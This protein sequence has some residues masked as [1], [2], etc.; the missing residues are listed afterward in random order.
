M[1]FQLSESSK[2]MSVAEVVEGVLLGFGQNVSINFSQCVKDGTVDF[3]AFE[4]AIKLIETKDFK[5]VLEGI[6]ALA[7]ASKHVPEDLMDCDG[8][9]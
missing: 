9:L 1:L 8:A 3:K 5:K 7:E 2:L 6:K 4:D